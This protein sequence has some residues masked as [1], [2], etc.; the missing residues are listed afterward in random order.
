MIVFDL[1]ADARGVVLEEPLAARR[2]RLEKLAARYFAGQSVVRL[3]PATGKLAVAKRWLRGGGGDLDGVIAKP[4]DLAYQA[5]NRVGMLKVKRIRTADCVVG[6]VRLTTGTRKAA[7]L[8][9]G[10]YDS[11]GL[12]HH[13]GF[14]AGFS[15]IDRKAIT[16]LVTPLFGPPSFTGR[17]PGG[18]S[19]W[20]NGRPRPWQ[21]LRPKLVVE[22][23]YDQVTSDRFRH[24]YPTIT[25]AA[26]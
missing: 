18:P 4:T 26:R 21:P 11:A 23:Q 15:A 22:V 17:A 2:E 24:G 13:V 5:G 7:S 6:G 12:L 16:R 1:L 3:S 10:L 20:S 19:R 14:T 25:F 9:L 8:L